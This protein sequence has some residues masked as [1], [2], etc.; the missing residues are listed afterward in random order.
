MNSDAF[1][2][3]SSRTIPANDADDSPKLDAHDRRSVR[4]IPTLNRN[5][6][7]GISIVFPPKT[8]QVKIYDLISPR[9]SQAHFLR[10]Q[11]THL[12]RT[13]DLLLQRLIAGK[14][15]V[16]DLDIAFPPGME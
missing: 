6:L 8:L 7:N 14:L 2:P 9:R 15:S 16:E 1:A 13:R 12:T 4:D 11:N 10:E 5:H 3:W